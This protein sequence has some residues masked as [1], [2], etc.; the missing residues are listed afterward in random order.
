MK[1][2]LH[3]SAYAA[4]K[5]N[6]AAAGLKPWLFARLTRWRLMAAAQI[7]DAT[8]ILVVAILVYPLSGHALGRMPPRYFMLAVAATVTCHFIFLLGRLYDFEILIDEARALKAIVTR[9]TFGF[10]VAAALL[11][12]AHDTEL[13]SRLWL[14]GF[15][16]GGMAALAG[17]RIGVSFVIRRWIRRGYSSKNIVVVGDNELTKLLIKRLAEGTSGIKVAGIFDD[18]AAGR[19]DI[20]GVPICGNIDDLLE[21]TKTNATDL[22]ILTLPVSATERINEVLKKLRQ[23]PLNLRL[24][25]GEIGLDRTSAIRH[26]RED[27][28]GVRLIVVSDRPISEVALFVKGTMD[29]C[30]AI[31]GLVIIAPLLLLCA[32][33]IAINSPGPVF[34]RQKRVGY[35]GQEFDIIKFR[36]MH[37]AFCGS[38]HPTHRADPRIFWFGR[39]L[40]KMSFDELPQLLNVVKGE[41]SLVGPRPHMVG[42]LV[43]GRTFFEAVNEYAGRHRVKPGITGWAQVNG[44]RG[45]TRT[46]AQIERRVEHDIYYIENWSLMLDLLILIKTAFVGFF[47]KNVF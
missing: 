18:R 1:H 47:G 46:L 15:Y 36:T 30:L 26:S 19:C 23:Q 38:R 45:P 12:L 14:L 34:F 44:W 29:R 4:P 5:F 41:M 39:L 7:L 13:V 17:E 33:G 11:V 31:I 3:Q 9:W 22:V 2:I 43:G 28:P 24:L 32:I 20:E 35:K 27:L 37:V 21:Y 8:T 10:L 40:R 6:A 42:Q 16:A 25:P